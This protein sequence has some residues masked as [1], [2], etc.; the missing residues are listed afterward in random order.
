MARAKGRARACLK[1]FIGVIRKILGGNG[2]AHEEGAPI[3]QALWGEKTKN[4]KV[5]IPHN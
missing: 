2:P 1:K 3:T 5:W 4:Q